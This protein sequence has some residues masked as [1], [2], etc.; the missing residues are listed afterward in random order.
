MAVALVED[1]DPERALARSDAWAAEAERLR[2]SGVLRGYQSLSSL[3]PSLKTQ[4]ERRA[5]WE[6][7]GAQRIAG[8]LRAALEA[9]GFEIDPFKPF[10]S[11]LEAPPPPILLADARKF[12]LDFMARNHV[13]ES[14]R[15]SPSPDGARKGV[16]QA[17][18]RVATFFFPQQGIDS[19]A[20]LESLI[21]FSRA[22]TG[23]VVTGVPILE[24]VLRQIVIADTVRVTVVSSLAVALLL[25]LYYR[26]WRPW[27][28]VM[29]PLLFSWVLFGAIFGAFHLP[30][31]LF[32]LLS[33]PLV[34]GYGIDD[35]IF[36]VHR[37]L[38]DPTA[39]PGRALASTGRAVLVT[40][41]ATISGFA[42]MAIARF[43]G[44]KLFGTSGAIAVGCCLV[45][46]IIVLPALLAL[47]WKKSAT[48]T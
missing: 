27:V 14:S 7:L 35:H 42:G 2:K 16:E 34:I 28:A 30:L 37:H 21:A 24:K 29:A 6:A 22:P 11:Q 36:I 20:A 41:L 15:P 48:R 19:P 44:L 23:G 10:L 17:L 12:D 46:A 1:A 45:G 40:S 38:D 13:H 25:A 32:N 43:D 9:A 31:N 8:D 5:R 3:F 39:D 47:M 4:N 18:T 33:V 26:R